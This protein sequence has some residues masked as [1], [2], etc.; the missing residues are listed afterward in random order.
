M[1]A[2]I[3]EP[4]VFLVQVQQVFYA[5]EPSTPW[6]KMVLHKEPR[7]KLVV[8]ENSEKINIHV[9]NV[10]DTE[11]PIQILEASSDTTLVGA[12]ELTGAD[13][14]LAVEGFKGLLMMM[15][16]RPWAEVPVLI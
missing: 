4:Y 6:W 8:V 15:K 12:I 10:I 2:N 14:I 11:A 9:D 16:R 3:D 5:Y 1:N 13:A 7:S